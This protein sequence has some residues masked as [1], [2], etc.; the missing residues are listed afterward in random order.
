MRIVIAG[1]SGFL[2]RR[3]SRQWLAAGD[4]VTVLSR[5]P[6]RASRRFDPAVEVVRWAPPTV[7]AALTELLG[8]ADAVVNLA[9]API[10]G[11][12]WTP[13]HKRAILSSRLDATHAIGEAMRRLPADRRPRTLVNASGIDVYGDRP[14]G[15]MTESSSAGGTFLAGVV[16][17]WEQAARE[18]EA[19]GVRV[20]LAR[21]ALVV[22][23]EALAW[24]LIVLPF[25]LFLGG[26]LGSGQQ[27]FTWIHVVDAVGL[28]DRA[29]RDDS[30]SGPFNLV[31][32]EVPTQVE[33]ARAIGR[34]MRRPAVFPVPAPLLRVALWGQADIVLHGRNAKPERAL[35]AGYRFAFPTVESA[36]RDVVAGTG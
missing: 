18:A 29:V 5:D 12:P 17:A 31:A 4:Q 1:G 15:T 33:L 20:V 8:R 3:L 25:R 19:S 10:G 32:P 35:A 2:G 30:V 21:T 11:R 9:G 36:L 16:T 24:R 34:V 22:A 13:G 23:P 14:T 28:Y 26:R 7:D 6:A 27:R